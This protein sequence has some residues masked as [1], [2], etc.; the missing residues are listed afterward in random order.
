MHVLAIITLMILSAGQSFD[1]NTARTHQHDRLR[2]VE[3]HITAW[4]GC[5]V[6]ATIN[7]TFRQ[8]FMDVP[9]CALRTKLPGNF[10]AR[11]DE[12][13]GAILELTNGP[14][15]ATPMPPPCP[16]PTPF[17]TPSPSP[18]P[19]PTPTPSP[20][21]LIQLAGKAFIIFDGSPFAFTKVVLTDAAGSRREFFTQDGSY[22]FGV[23][24]GSYQLHIEHDGWNASPGRIYVVNATASTGGLSIMNFTLGP[25][26]WFNPGGEMCVPLSVPCPPGSATPSPT[27][28]V[29]P[30]PT[31][32]ATPTPK[33]SPTPTPTPVPT[34][35]PTPTPTPQPSPTPGLPICRRDEVVGSPPR[36]VCIGQLVGNPRRC[37]PR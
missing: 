28:T 29:T 10:R 18:S 8:L 35:L 37:K 1:C 33:P 3:V 27:P 4:S 32:T 12:T 11:I 17:P 9:D 20:G 30:T 21:G 22:L 2:D 24:P 6:S 26:S 23:V 19:V 16:T 36:C 14:A 5:T 34:P 13:C 7:G 31:P 25:S 15:I